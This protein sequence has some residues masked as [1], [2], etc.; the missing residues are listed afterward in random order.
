MSE[1][2]FF[3]LM[4]SRKKLSVILNLPPGPDLGLVGQ[5]NPIEFLPAYQRYNGIIYQESN[6]SSVYPK[7]SAKNVIII[8]A[9]YGVLDA[10]ELIRNYELKMD[11]TLPIGAK[12]KTWWKS[13]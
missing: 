1:E 4:T 3:K 9:L 10:N 6:F 2:N 7:L 12:V 8:S 13:P 11:H 5:E